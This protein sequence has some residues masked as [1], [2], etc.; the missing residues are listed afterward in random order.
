MGNLRQL[1][2]RLFSSLWFIP[3]LIITAAIL[4]AVVLVTVDG[5]LDREDLEQWPRLF[6]AGTDGSRAMLS[7]IAQSMITVAGVVFSITIVALSMASNQ[8]SPRILRTFMQSTATQVVLGTFVGIFAYCLVVLRT[9]RSG[10]E[11]KFVPAVAVLAAVGL[12]LVG[13]AFLVFFIHHIASSIQVTTIMDE[14]TAE[15]FSGVD[16][17]FPQEL[18]DEQEDDGPPPLLLQIQWQPV[19]SLAAGYLQSLEEDALLR[20][21]QER[22]TTIRLESSIGGFVAEGTPLVSVP[23]EFPLDE[24]TV[25]EL[26][27]PF[28]IDRFRTT[29]QDASFGI[30][31]LVDIALKAMS[32]G[33]NDSR[34]AV[35][36]VDHLMAILIRVARRR[37]ANPYRYAE[38]H[39]R[40]VA[41]GP[42][43][44]SLV[45]DA[46]EPIRR[47]GDFAVIN[48]M[49]EA[50]EII[51][52]ATKNGQRRQVLCEQ[53]E[54][55]REAL[56]DRIASQHD[57]GLLR[58]RIVEI[59]QRVQRGTP[60]SS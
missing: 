29:E 32:T 9:I 34:T 23:R 26:N 36:C 33:V 21:A 45:Q 17:L 22:N 59:E 10:D 19:R 43:F 48:R 31:L 41:H 58:R 51:A 56:E 6:G 40:V 2:T 5:Y 38:G 42:T 7:A 53:L 8:F 20:F 12:A 14:I 57:R 28:A 25:R 11:D 39:L 52:D 30:Q 54:R 13:V 1:W 15:T 44:R 24:D 60:G 4:L 46:F 35:T 37:V 3:G 16:R 55:L 50:I 18:G 49:A 27:R 47:F